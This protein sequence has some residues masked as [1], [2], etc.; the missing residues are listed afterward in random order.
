MDE[1]TLKMQE[2]KLKRRKMRIVNHM[3]INRKRFTEKWNHFSDILDLICASYLSDFTKED[4]FAMTDFTHEILDIEF[5][6]INRLSDLDMAFMTAT[7]APEELEDLKLKAI[8][9]VKISYEVTIREV[10]KHYK[11]CV[12]LESSIRRCLEFRGD[13]NE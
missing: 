11:D 12:K 1:F 10:N 3:I 13:N 6:Y 4:F 2:K 9:R 5:E 7:D 8:E